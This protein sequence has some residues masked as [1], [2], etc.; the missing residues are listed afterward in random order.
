MR[1]LVPLTVLTV[2]C[3][4]P[5][6]EPT[7]SQRTLPEL[8]PAVDVDPDPRVVEI[9]LVAEPGDVEI[10]PG[11]STAMWT[12]R[13]ENA[14][15]QAR[16]VGPLIEAKVG[17]RLV[18][19]LTNAL[20]DS[21]TL[22]WH[23]L[24]L[25]NEMDGNPMV[26]GSIDPGASAT[27]DFVLQDAGLFWYHPHVDSDQQVERG[28]QGALL[29]RGDDE[30]EP[31]VE[32][33]LMLDDVDLDESGALVLEPSMDDLMFGRRG[34]VL[35][36]NGA[37]PGGASA[38]PGSLERWRVVNSANG[39]FFALALA[40][41]SLRVI[42]GD[43]G[44][45]ATSIDLDEVVIA[46]GERTDVLVTIPGERGDVLE[47]VTGAVPRGPDGADEGP[48]TL[49]ELSLD[50][51]L[52]V[53]WPT[54]EVVRD[55]EPLVVDAATV[56]RSFEL[57]SQMD[58]PAGPI[59]F[60]NDQRWPFNQPLHVDFGQTEIWKLVNDGEHEHP[61]HLHGLFFQVLDKD[62]VPEPVLSWKD[63]VQ[64]SAGGTTRFVVRYDAPG[65]WMYH[66][67]ILEHAELGMMGD[68]HVME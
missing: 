20:P 30:P 52:G 39:R 7:P 19:R 6:D 47:L 40:Q 42:G 21:T 28:L 22:H 58:S 45:A 64:V 38:Q 1:T 35:L 29:V 54:P 37:I 43:G 51:D 17:D 4:A 5:N 23:G 18:V 11:S 12:Y 8:A 25:P 2:G 10:L 15:A 3:S 26:S 50:S 63:T 36:V 13:D 66:C 55:I 49:I 60:I 27:V 16:A 14:S 31:D 67:Q 46:P 59:F 61:F 9:H 62:G 24:R 56:T 34:N 33:V 48:F 53:V 65:M 44:L 41:R 57:T 68:L 32:R